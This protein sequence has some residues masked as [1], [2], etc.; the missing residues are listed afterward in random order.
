MIQGR[1]HLLALTLILS[2]SA[3]FAGSVR[4][5]DFVYAQTFSQFA[6]PITTDQCSLKSFSISNYDQ[7]FEEV[8]GGVKKSARGTM[9][10]TVVETTDPS[11]IHDYAVVQYIHGCVYDIEQSDKTGKLERYYGEDIDDADGNSIP[12]KFD[13][14]TV[15]SVDHDPMYFSAPASSTTDPRRF[16]GLLYTTVPLRLDGTDAG[17]SADMTTMFNSKYLGFVKDLPAPPKQMFSYDLPDTASW[18]GYR[19]GRNAVTNNSLEFKVC[20]YR[21]VDV[22]LTGSPK[23]FDVPSDQGGPIHCID[24]ESKN[25]F[26]FKSHQ[27]VSN[28]GAPIDPFCATPVTDSNLHPTHVVRRHAA[29]ASRRP[30]G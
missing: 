26:D 9:I 29:L 23:G 16:D 12:F 15:D 21:T 8:D 11:C 30:R 4:A 17:L 5:Q 6:P 7:G 10:G 20:L 18:Y 22:P 24:W 27:I 19:T 28:L 1:N 2:T 25:S 14:W 3:L 13:D